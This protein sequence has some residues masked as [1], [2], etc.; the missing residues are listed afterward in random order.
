[1]IVTENQ[2]QSYKIRT[3]RRRSSLTFE[4]IGFQNIPQITHAQEPI[5]PGHFKNYYQKY[6]DEITDEWI[7]YRVA[8]GGD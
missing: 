4:Q 3:F 6:F 7:A 2:L 8:G 1:M 5:C